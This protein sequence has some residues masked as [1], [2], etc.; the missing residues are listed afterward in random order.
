MT[1]KRRK[2]KLPP[3]PP[4][5]FRYI[6]YPEEYG[7]VHRAWRAKRVKI[8]DAA[9]REIATENGVDFERHR[10]AMWALAEYLIEIP[11]EPGRK[12]VD[13]I[14]LLMAVWRE[15]Q[16]TDTLE[17]AVEKTPYSFRTFQKVRAK[18]RVTWKVIKI[19][20]PD[21]FEKWMSDLRSLRAQE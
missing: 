11:S 8:A 12:A 21:V 2:V 17:E 5:Y 13:P 6:D 3:P 4:L 9:L 15:R 7:P 18:N 14:A 16:D 10:D 1:R 20:P 19:A